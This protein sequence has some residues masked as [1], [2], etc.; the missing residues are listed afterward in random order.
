M[1]ATTYDI[2]VNPGGSIDL[3]LAYRTSG[4]DPIDLEGKAA[5]LAIGEAK[6]H[7]GEVEGNRIRFHVKPG[8]GVD[9]EAKYSVYLKDFEHGSTEVLMTGFIRVASDVN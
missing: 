4:G 7:P 1:S 2:F 8:K 9:H 5:F 6:P 3:D